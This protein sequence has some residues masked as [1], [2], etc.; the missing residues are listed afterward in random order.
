[1]NNP[2]RVM[3]LTESERDARRIA[4]TLESAG[5]RAEVDRVHSRDEV[6]ASLRSFE[7][8]FVLANP[9]LKSPEELMALVRAIRPTAPAI[10]VA[11]RV[12]ERTTV[13][14]IRAGAADVIAEKDLEASIK[15]IHTAIEARRNL[16]KL[17]PRQIEVLRLVS[18]GHTTREIA[19]KL[20]LS[21]KTI[22]T[23]RGELMKRLGIHDVVSLV[24]YAVRVGLVE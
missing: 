15:T 16:S 17:S 12:D 23:H 9:Y 24:R 18:D 7:P 6:A 21:V 10:F 8:E 1:M 22:E 11:E 5:I 3:L 14:C 20:K 4:E 19:K 2:M 13:S